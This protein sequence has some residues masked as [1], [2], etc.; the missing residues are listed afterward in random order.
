M[1]YDHDKNMPQT[2]YLEKYAYRG[3]T[4]GCHIYREPDNSLYF[5]TEGYLSTSNAGE[6]VSEVSGDIYRISTINGSDILPHKNVDNNMQLLLGLEKDKYY[7]FEFYQGTKYRK[8]T[9]IADTIV[10]QSEDMMILN[11][12][13]TN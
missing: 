1:I 6:S 4:I 13:Y 2:Y 11:N 3:Y 9:T 5:S 8:L 10:L 12:P 7:D